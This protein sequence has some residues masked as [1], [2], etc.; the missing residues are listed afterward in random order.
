MPR[1]ARGRPLNGQLRVPRLVGALLG[2]LI[3]LPADA[4]R[5]DQNVVTSADDAFGTSVGAQ[6]I[7]LYS[8]TDARGFNP[9][10]AGNLRIEGLYFDTPTQYIAECLVRESTMRIGIAA[11]SYSFPSPTGIADVKL[12]IPGDKTV[13]SGY[14]SHGPFGESTALLEV[15]GRVSPQFAAFACVGTQRDFLSDAAEHSSNVHAASLLRWQPTERLEILPFVAL[16]TGS[17][18]E[19][20]P[21]VYTESS[22]VSYTDGAFGAPRFGL[23]P[24]PLF[25]LR[26]LAAQS[27]TT[28]G[29]RTTT[30]GAI[31]RYAPAAQWSL[32][33]GVFRVVEQDPRTFNDE[34]LSILPNRTADHQLDVTPPYKSASTSGELRVARTFGSNT[35]ARTFEV[36]VRGRRSN[37]DYGG[38][39]T[40]DYGVVNIDSPPPLAPATY[41]T[42]A[43]S[44]DE[45]RQ[46]DAGVL[47]EERWQGVGTLAMGL[48]R[49][50]YERTIV[51]PTLAPAA[52]K[53]SP[54]LGSLRFTGTPA[55]GV[56]LYGSF[57]QGLEDAALAPITSMN[58]G[59]PPLASRTHQADGGLRWAPDG[60]LSVVFG[61]FEI[62]KAY[63][64][65]DAANVYTVLGTVRHRG[66][67][68]SVTYAHDG[69]KLV[70]GGVLL[71]PH[72]DRE[73]AEPGATGLVPLGPVPLTLTANV[74]CAP[75]RWRPWAA[76]VQWNYLSSRAVT[77][78]DANWLPR[79]TT[80]SAGVRYESTVR[81]HPL[82][83]RFDAVNLTDARG[84]RVTSLEQVIP[85]L[86]R[87]LALSVAI[88]N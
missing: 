19:V 80:I 29:W 9:Q 49:S 21:A 56:T 59:Q 18:R 86:G 87:R 74:D 7:G 55:A 32:T 58:R 28:Q 35:H 71:R 85:D 88:D 84:L 47:Y 60:R 72:V 5:A 40:P 31:A 8:M 15:Q 50:H 77:Q 64:N 2:A 61:A 79:F 73:L 10:Q 44:I 12:P 46:L 36:A 54:W 69:F 57:V 16:Q 23:P 14:A 68:S 83:I 13:V 11:Q 82:T 22:P 43:I 53:S 4:Q 75:P 45:T 65:L 78:D 66:L 76:S 63:L 17:D 33:L 62:D 41:A 48:L 52:A 51:D 67:E 20:F 42:T 37:K 1:S 27:F 81:G 25:D 70:A 26:H 34:Y 6:S 39:A 30:F 24:P 3:G 38:D